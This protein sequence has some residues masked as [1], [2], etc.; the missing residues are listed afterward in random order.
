MLCGSLP[1]SES[2]EDIIVEKIKKHDYKIPD[3]LSNEAQDILNHILKINP[4]E[5]FNIE[6][7]KKHPWFNIVEP[8]LMNA[9]NY[10]LK[11][12]FVL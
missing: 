11:I 8:H 5:R 6:S 2:K 9:K 12:N 3:Y 10:Y 1:F 7:I 4:E